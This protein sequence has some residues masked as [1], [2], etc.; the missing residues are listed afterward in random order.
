MYYKVLKD[1]KVIDVLDRLIFVKYQQKHG[2]MLVCD[3]S[4]AQAIM[5]SDGVYAWHVAG[6]YR[7]PVEGYDTV[8]LVSIDEYEYRRLKILN[9]RT[10]Q[11]II[12]E[13]VLS[14]IE[15]DIL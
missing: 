11:E 6:L 7:I 8:K 9:M 2:I 10:P 13:F 3:K 5:S 15:E 4:E 14:L 12:D 1:N